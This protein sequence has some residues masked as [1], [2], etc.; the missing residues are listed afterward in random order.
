[1]STERIKVNPEPLDVKPIPVCL[2]CGMRAPWCKCGSMNYSDPS[3]GV[4]EPPE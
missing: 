3:E 4:R 1:M 2:D